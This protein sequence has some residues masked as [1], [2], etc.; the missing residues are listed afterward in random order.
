MDNTQSSPQQFDVI[1]V[2]GGM[3]G[4]ATAIG[5][6][7]QNYT[8][9]LIEQHALREYKQDQAPDIRLSAFNMHSVRLLESLGAWHYVKQMRYREY[10]SLSVWEEPNNRT[11]FS[12]EEV[13]HECLGY[14]VENRLIQ[15]GLYQSIGQNHSER[16]SCIHGQSI[17]KIDVNEGTVALSDGQSFVADLIVGAD[18][19]NS[20]VRQAAN[21]ATHG[22][23]YAQR[24]NAILIECD[25]PI[26]A[27][28]WQQFFPSGPRALLPMHNN[29]ACLVWYDSAEK[30]TWIQQASHQELAHAIKEAFP[31]LLPAFNIVQVAGFD[32][33][34][35][36]ANQYGKG[37][38]IIV[39]DAAHTINPLAGQGVNLG[40]KDVA[41]LI[42]IIEKN[43]TLEAT[44]IVSELEK[45]R[46][47]PN[48]AM[49][50]TMDVLYSAFST[51][52][53][54]IKA[55]RNVGLRIANSAGP[56][57]AQVLKYAMG[58]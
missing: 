16:I 3:V 25:A 47:L 56:I 24:A 40:F 41:S 22:W 33:T 21:I 44:L 2:G 14:F 39:G 13:G 29:Y 9:A 46:K 37:K 1:I 32:L 11:T 55:I 18:G 38:S 51:P 54:P 30:S 12:A 15:L 53:L 36:H 50:S 43:N 23:Q 34:R 57:K 8:V 31:P 48:L 52:L 6:A 7:A 35:M 45:Q 27:Q 17:A 42:G 20:Q 4:A 28:T 10:D 26:A 19:A 5:L 58:L 49:M